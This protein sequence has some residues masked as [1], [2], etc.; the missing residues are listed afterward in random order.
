MSAKLGFKVEDAE[1]G[2]PV[3]IRFQ[4]GGRQIDHQQ[5]EVGGVGDGDGRDV[6]KVF[7]T[8]ML[9]AVAEIELN[10]ETQAVVI[11][12]LGCRQG[13]VGA[14]QDDMTAFAGFAVG[15]DDDHDVELLGMILVVNQQVIRVE[16]LIA[17]EFGRD[18]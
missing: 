17:V 14:K 11:D 8:P 10:L 7:Q 13:Q 15:L 9:L 6:H 1:I 18:A 5:G 2:L 12:D 3:A 4:K 16:A